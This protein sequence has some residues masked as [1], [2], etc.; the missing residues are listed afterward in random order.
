MCS[1]LHLAT[2]L[3]QIQSL[4]N[5]RTCPRIYIHPPR[6]NRTYI[7]TE[8]EVHPLHEWITPLGEMCARAGGGGGGGEIEQRRAACPK[9]R[10]RSQRERGP[11]VYVCIIYICITC[12]RECSVRSQHGCWISGGNTCV[13]GYS[14]PRALCL[15]G[16]VGVSFVW[17][18]FEVC[19]CGREKG[20]MEF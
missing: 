7:R 20:G 4:E 8:L 17:G 18:V 16:E 12:M 1:E 19:V 15:F 14:A 13:C 11:D 10:S 6:P 5:A 2:P 3:A 9:F